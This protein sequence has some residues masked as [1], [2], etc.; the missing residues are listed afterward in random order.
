MNY[1]LTVLEQKKL[2]FFLNTKWNSD[3]K[4]KYLVLVTMF[5]I[6]TTVYA[7]KNC[8]LTDIAAK[9]SRTGWIA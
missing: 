3:M 4:M 8:P 6:S 7:K 5:S 9:T 1:L 2:Y